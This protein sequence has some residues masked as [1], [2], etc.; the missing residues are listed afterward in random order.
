MESPHPLAML[1][2]QT[3]GGN[4]LCEL[5]RVGTQFSPPGPP[6]LG[7]CLDGGKLE[8]ALGTL[9]TSREM[10]RLSPRSAL[11]SPPSPLEPAGQRLGSSFSW[12][13]GQE[14]LRD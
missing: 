4:E 14:L 13:A 2:P 3:L 8:E 10:P 9:I 5:T 12:L 7:T 1:S 11:F 6:C